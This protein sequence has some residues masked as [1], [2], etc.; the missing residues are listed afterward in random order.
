[1][2]FGEEQP[3]DAEAGCDWEKDGRQVAY[4]QEGSALV[5]DQQQEV[6]KEEDAVG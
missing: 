6:A 5:Q 1:V 3:D 2:G 4:Q